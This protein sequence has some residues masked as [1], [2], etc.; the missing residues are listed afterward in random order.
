MPRESHLVDCNVTDLLS[1]LLGLDLDTDPQFDIHSFRFE[2][3]FLVTLE[4]HRCPF[5]G[6]AESDNLEC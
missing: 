4:H 1:L 3:Q 5:E 2:C 6:D